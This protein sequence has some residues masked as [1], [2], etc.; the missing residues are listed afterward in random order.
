MSIYCDTSSLIKIYIEEIGSKETVKIINSVD[1]IYVSQ[2]TIF[3][4]IS[5]IRRLLLE[6]ALDIKDYDYLKKQI[7]SDFR[8]FHIVDLSKDIEKKIIEVIDL[9]QLKTLDAIQL[10]TFLLL[11][12]HMDTSFVVCDKKLADCVRKS[13]QPVINPLDNGCSEEEND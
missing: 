9:Y 10:A 6:K 12:K 11:P 7:Q 2:I 1:E 13:K 4:C 5:V 3:E 8:S